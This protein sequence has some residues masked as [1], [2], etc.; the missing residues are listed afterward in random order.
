MDPRAMMA[1]GD[2]LQHDYLGGMG[3]DPDQWDMSYEPVKPKLRSTSEAYHPGWRGLLEKVGPVLGEAFSD[4]D[5]QS[6]MARM[7]AR[8]ARA[9]GHHLQSGVEDR[10]GDI[11]AENKQ[12]IGAADDQNAMRRTQ[13]AQNRASWLSTAR[14]RMPT[15]RAVLQRKNLEKREA[16]REAAMGHVEGTVAARTAAGMPASGSTPRTKTPSKYDPS[17]FRLFGDA[18]KIQIDEID[19]RAKDAEAELKDLKTNFM[20][21]QAFMPRRSVNGKPAAEAPTITAARMRIDD[22]N[23]A[24]AKARG[25]KS[26]AAKRALLWHAQNLPA[27]PNVALGTFAQ[28]LR[29][30]TSLGIDKDPEVNKALHDAAEALDKA[31]EK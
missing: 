28:L 14:D 25:E 24:V 22:L 19:Q 17:S 12:A 30:A 15:P 2:T 5:W 26:A 21:K 8:L 3:L 16:A 27:D 7:A 23:Q 4:A 11:T 6:P 13:V 10:M 31:G 18:D 1:A 29:S 20:T 9:Y